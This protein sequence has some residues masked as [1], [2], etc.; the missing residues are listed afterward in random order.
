ML[1]LIN[2]FILA[3]L[4]VLAI[5]WGSISFIIALIVSLCKTG[6]EKELDRP[7]DFWERWKDIF[8]FGL[9]VLP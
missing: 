1:I 2:I 7:S 9:M 4:F 3:A 6:I 5:I 8:T